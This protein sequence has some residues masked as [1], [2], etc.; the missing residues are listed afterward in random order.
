[1]TAAGAATPTRAAIS[2]VVVS[3]DSG[4]C[5]R[6][7]VA[8]LLLQPEVMEI[9]V[10]DNASSDGAPARLPGAGRVRLLRNAS[11]LGFSIACNQG[12][13]ATSGAHL[14]FINPDCELPAG[15]LAQMR[16]ALDAHP[17]IGVL[18]AQLLNEDGS[19]QAAAR[20]ATPTPRRALRSLLGLGSAAQ[21][22]RDARPAREGP[23]PARVER[24]D[25]IS[26]ALMLMPRE[27]FDRLGGFD[28]G[29]VLHCEDLDLCRRVPALGLEVAL[30]P[31]LR[32]L[33]RKGTS[34]RRRPYWVEWQK[35]RGMAR[36]FHKFDAAASPIWMRAAVP[37]G[38]ALHF[39][40][41]CARIPL[42]QMGNSP[43]RPRSE[44]PRT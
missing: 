38:I 16:A 36:Y 17:T 4:E 25:A 32:V 8:A 34:S 44:A 23:G 40:M 6:R 28:E 26:G 5:L 24:V 10:V 1:M 3:H 21:G 35:H 37:L 15:A 22:R 43:A 14:L 42:R 2:A 30:L 33:H 9:C 13:A 39:L 31:D 12:A 7:C 41:T 27:V 19:P 29:Y 20:R 18:G 11:N